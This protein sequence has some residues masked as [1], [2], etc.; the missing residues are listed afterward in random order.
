MIPFMW[1]YG[2]SARCFGD[3]F[4][5][6]CVSSESRKGDGNRKVWSATGNTKGLQKQAANQ[7]DPC[8]NKD[9]EETKRCL[10]SRFL[11][12]KCRETVPSYPEFGGRLFFPTFSRK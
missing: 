11:N 4:V 10:E 3:F 9:A 2:D 8:V 6:G 7:P 1:R 5:K 12:L